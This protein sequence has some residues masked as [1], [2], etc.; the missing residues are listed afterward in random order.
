MKKFIITLIAAFFVFSISYN[1]YT[2]PHKKK[3]LFQDKIKDSVLEEEIYIAGY[4]NAVLDFCN[5]SMVKDH[6]EYLKNLKGLVG[7]INWDLFKFFLRG[8]STLESELYNAGIGWGGQY[9]LGGGWAPTPIEFSFDITACDTKSIEMALENNLNTPANI[10]FPFI[11]EKSNDNYIEQLEI[12]KNKLLS[13]KRD[14]YQVFAEIIINQ[15]SLILEKKDEE[16][17]SEESE[18]STKEP[19]LNTVDEDPATR[20]KKLKSWFDEGIISKEDYE[21]KKKEILDNI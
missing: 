17:I 21:T 9:G 13:D 6:K 15:K 2:F 4:Y 1:A 10:L 8:R 5:Y 19:E 16:I 12:L 11:K 20:L 18:E 3:S 7:Y 14:D